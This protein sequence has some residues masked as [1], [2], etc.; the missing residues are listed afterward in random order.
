MPS[1]KGTAS[2]PSDA[3]QTKLLRSTKFPPSFAIPV[4]LT[5][6]NASVMSQWIEKKIETILGF[7]DD[8][9]S[10]MAIHLFFPKLNEDFG[11]T[12][13][14][15]H[16]ISSSTS[17]GTSGS[18]SGS[19]SG[20]TTKYAP[21]DPRKSQLDLEGFL[22]KEE[23]ANFCTE[24]WE[25]LIDSQDQPRGIPKKLI[26][27]KKRDLAAASAAATATA[28]VTSVSARSS[29]STLPSRNGT[30]HVPRNRMN[31][32]TSRWSN[33]PG[34]SRFNQGVSRNE[35][36]SLDHGDKDDQ[37]TIRRGD[38][39][40]TNNSSYSNN[41][42]STT[43]VSHSTTS[44]RPSG[45]GVMRDRE[46]IQGHPFGS[47]YDKGYHS[48]HSSSADSYGR[49]RGRTRRRSG[50]EHQSSNSNGNPNYQRRRWDRYD[51]DSGQR[52]KTRTTT[53]RRRRTS[54]SPSRSISRSSSRSFSRTSNHQSSYNGGRRRRSKSRSRSRSRS[55]SSRD[56]YN[57]SGSRGSR[58]N[59]KRSR[60][61][62]RSQS[63][64]NRRRYYSDGKSS[65]RC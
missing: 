27:E 31:H 19:G 8:I 10:S 64:N 58:Y 41:R 20:S 53:T 7:E 39:S 40:T 15:D 3:A 2:I 9:V 56:K 17:G 38:Y 51:D 12:V 61:R 1:I 25:M 65:R 45:D 36:H 44:R 21:V 33:D 34:S 55:T 26:E 16:P 6:V 50:N 14:S 62:S 11:S 29:E 57:Q 23:A 13:T 63:P 52:D 32:T 35:R 49:K 48:D 22:G 24:L 37:G 5:K 43:N 54:G 30:E 42:S 47:R 59:S 4:D 18:G 46:G 60:S 28:K